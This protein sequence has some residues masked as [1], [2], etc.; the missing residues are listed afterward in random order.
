MGAWGYG[1]LQN[2]TIQ[3]GLC[4]VSGEIKESVEEWTEGSEANAARLGAAVGLLLRFSPYSFDAENPFSQKWVQVLEA[5]QVYFDRLPGETGKI[6]ERVRNGEGAEL[7]E[8]FGILPNPLY[9]AFYE[10]AEAQETGTLP[11]PTCNDLFRHPDAARWL[12]EQVEE[13]IELVDDGLAEDDVV[14]DL[15]REGEFMGA[16]AVHA[17]SV[18]SLLS[19]TILPAGGRGFTR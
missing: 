1:I 9:V 8:R 17:N 14:Y 7:A 11:D 3:D 12:G 4:E 5:N 15:A 13:W 18:L 10:D 2:D 19:P 16:F 6:L